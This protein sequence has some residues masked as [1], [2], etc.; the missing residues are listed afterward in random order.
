MIKIYKAVFENEIQAS[1]YLFNIG[2]YV[3]IEDEGIIYIAYSENTQSVV[4]IGKIVDKNKTIDPQNPIYYPGIAYD[5]MS[6][7][8][9]NFGSYEVYPKDNSTHSFYGWPRN[10]EV[11]K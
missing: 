6:S 4:N 11:P 1:D 8:E 3:E 7:A 2:V 5:I 9:L 10:A